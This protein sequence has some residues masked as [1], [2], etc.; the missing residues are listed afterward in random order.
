MGVSPCLDLPDRRPVDTAT[1]AQ[2][3]QCEDR[4][5]PQGGW[6]GGFRQQAVGSHRRRCQIEFKL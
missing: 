2:P 3:R 5:V 4:S 6:P 1:R